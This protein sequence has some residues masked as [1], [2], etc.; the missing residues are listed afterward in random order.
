[1]RW[2]LLICTIPIAIV[3]NAGR[4]TI[5][6]I[7]SEIDPELATGVFHETEGFI[8]FAIALVMLAAT[9]ALINWVANLRQVPELPSDDDS[10]AA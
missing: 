9:H 1:M 4:V 7:L 2:A 8:I 10:V 6:G 3:A 5:T